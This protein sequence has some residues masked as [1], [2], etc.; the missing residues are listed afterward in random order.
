MLAEL[1]AVALS[2]DIIIYYAIGLARK[3]QIPAAQQPRF[4]KS[5]LRCLQQQYGFRWRRAYGE[6]SSVNL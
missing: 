2:G 3:L 4:G 6:A 5:W 1:E